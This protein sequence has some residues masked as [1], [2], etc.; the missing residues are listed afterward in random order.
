MIAF[1]LA[2]LP[3]KV[4]SGKIP[5]WNVFYCLPPL[6][7]HGAFKRGHKEVHKERLHPLHAQ[8]LG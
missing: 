2:P 7:K 4:H 1:G 8:A 6:A 3:M 5:C